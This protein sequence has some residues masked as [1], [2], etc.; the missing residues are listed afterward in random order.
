MRPVNLTISAFGPYAGKIEIDFE[1]IGENG[2]YLITG[3]TGAG[4]TTIFDAISFVL[5]GTPSGNDR[6][7]SM[8]RSL[9]AEAETDTFVE[10][11]FEYRG[12]IYKIR[13]SPSYMRPAKRGTGMTENKHSAELTL[14]D[15]KIVNSP[16]AVTDKITDI[17]GI[18]KNQFSQ[19]A[20]IAQGDFQKVLTASTDERQAIFRKVF[21]TGRYEKLQEKLENDVKQISKENAET[22]EKIKYS[23]ANISCDSDT[24]CAE[25]LNSLRQQEIPSSKE[26]LGVLDTII[27]SDNDESSR[28]SDS[29]LKIEAGLKKVNDN[30]STLNRFEEDQSKLLSAQKTLRQ[31][32][33]ELPTEEDFNKLQ[34]KRQTTKDDLNAQ[35]VKLNA[36]LP[37]YSQYNQLNSEIKSLEESIPNDEKTLKSKNDQAEKKDKDIAALKLE[38]DSLQRAGENLQVFNASLKEKKEQ[39][40]GLKDLSNSL[41]KFTTDSSDLEKWQE[42]VEKLIAQH[43]AAEANYTRLSNRFLAEQAGIMAE[44]LEEGQPCP[45]CGSVHHPHVA[46]KSQ[47]APSEIDVKNAK[48]EADKLQSRVVTGTNKCSTQRGVVNSQRDAIHQNTVKLFKEDIPMEQLSARIADKQNTLNQE[49]GSLNR[50]IETERKN[51]NRRDELAKLIPEE[52]GALKDLKEGENGILALTGKISADKAA[53]TEKRNLRDSMSKELEYKDLDSATSALKDL[54]KRRD[55]IQHEFDAANKERND[56]KAE[57]ERLNGEIKSLNDQLKAGCSIDRNKETEKLNELSAQKKQQLDRR[58]VIVGRQ[59]LNENARYEIERMS[60]KIESLAEEFLWKKSL[61]DTIGGKISGREKFSLETYVQTA[62]FDCIIERANER[63][64]IMSKGKYE[65]KR[66][67]SATKN[68]GQ[69]GLDLDVRDHY[70]DSLRDVK[71]LSGG[72]KFMASLALALGL[73]DEIQQSSGGVKLDTMFVDEGFGSLSQGDALD[74]VIRVLNELSQGSKL[75]GIIS[76]V[77]ELKKI[78]KQIVVKKQTTGGSTAEIII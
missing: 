34:M 76:H 33:D 78:D 41:S 39:L 25:Q 11:T 52:E 23:L 67:E 20:M 51:M 17:L 3:E 37:K 18:D 9:Y 50:D 77:E 57:I 1:K 40:N 48:E 59:K 65:L 35:M 58:D 26:I 13:R 56:A 72:E 38:N 42:G 49:I 7:P 47:D 44:H 32:K 71:S 29:I 5:F 8:L 4:K 2:L 27:R 36:D 43:T 53:L 15:G 55:G 19:I 31:K 62:Y 75:V 12:E 60:G 28:L 16:K 21:D 69:V 61:S 63:L 30:L 54:E 46:Q 24:P 14:P 74:N 64:K 45:V 68:R 66:R 73:S 6:D 70:N 10:M 22:Q